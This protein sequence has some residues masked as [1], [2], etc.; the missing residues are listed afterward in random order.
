MPPKKATTRSSSSAQGDED[1]PPPNTQGDPITGLNTDFNNEV[2]PLNTED[3]HVSN[4]GNTLDIIPE[5][6]PANGDNILTAERTQEQSSS[7]ISEAT[8]LAYRSQLTSSINYLGDLQTSF[9]MVTDE[10][11]DTLDAWDAQLN[12]MM[13]STP[14][15]MQSL[16]I[17]KKSLRALNKRMMELET[18]LRS[19]DNKSDDDDDARS[20]HSSSSSSSSS[21]SLP[22]TLI[23]HDSSQQVGDLVGILSGGAKTD[24]EFLAQPHIIDQVD[25]CL[26]AFNNYDPKAQYDSLHKVVKSIQRLTLTTVHF[27]S[28]K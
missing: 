4:T 10:E 11:A 8:L 12:A 1:P 13:N 2:L 17:T 6:T 25:D 23:T 9:L 21:S 5:N 14:E 3:A 15:D 16:Q 19:T 27:S 20:H 18:S 22:I 26:R 7:V 28:L 24:Q